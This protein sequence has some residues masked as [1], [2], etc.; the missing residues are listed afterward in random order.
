M[1]PGS[2]LVAPL[3]VNAD[4]ISLWLE[5]VVDENGGDWEPL[6]FMWYNADGTPR[7]AASGVFDASHLSKVGVEALMGF[8]RGHLD[9]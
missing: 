3:V 2:A 9:A 1:T 6:W 7:L 8:L 5:H 4:G